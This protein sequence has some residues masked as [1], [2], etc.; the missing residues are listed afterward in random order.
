MIIVANQADCRRL[1]KP[2]FTTSK[3]AFSAHKQSA[4]HP[5]AQQGTRP[6][7]LPPGKSQL[8]A[9][10]GGPRRA[11]AGGEFGGVARHAHGGVAAHVAAGLRGPSRPSA[12]RPAGQQAPP[13]GSQS[14]MPGAPAW[15][16]ALVPN[17]N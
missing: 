7:G 4:N 15:G 2:A 17:I 8:D 5:Q 10:G 3:P 9:A 6:I 11:R 13:I 12:R 16:R 14:G 1:S